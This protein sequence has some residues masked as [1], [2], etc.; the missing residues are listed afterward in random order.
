MQTESGKRGHGE[1]RGGSAFQVRVHCRAPV[2]LEAGGQRPLPAPRDTA[3]TPSP[4]APPRSAPP[5][6]AGSIPQVCGQIYLEPSPAAEDKLT[7]TEGLLSFLLT[8]G[9]LGAQH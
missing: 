8:G 4:G 3:G 1:Q 7:S 2:H 5:E 6:Q 9:R